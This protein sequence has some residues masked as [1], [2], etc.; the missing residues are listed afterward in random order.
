MDIIFSD[1]QSEDLLKSQVLQKYHYLTYVTDNFRY[2]VNFRYANNDPLW[3]ETKAGL[4]E[5]PHLKEI[6]TYY[7]N[8]AAPLCEEECVQRLR[9]GT[10]D[11]TMQMIRLVWF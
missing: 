5:K 6:V 3:Q 9:L 1:S 2:A 4:S 8:K 11:K 10:Y 7:Y